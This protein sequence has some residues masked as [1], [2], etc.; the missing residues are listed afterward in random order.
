[1]LSVVLTAAALSQFGA[2]V[3]HA[4]EMGSCSG[5]CEGCCLPTVACLQMCVTC[6]I[7]MNCIDNQA[8]GNSLLAILDAAQDALDNG[9]PRIAV[10]L[11][12][13]F[14]YEVQAEDGKHI[15]ADCA[16]HLLMHAQMVIDNINGS[17]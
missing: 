7:E 14:Q 1:M 17:A 3:A 8:V 9:R 6:C 12:T 16:S 2:I 5:S 11:L 10:L 15:D 4:Q 13:V